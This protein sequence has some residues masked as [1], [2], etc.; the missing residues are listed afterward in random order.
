MK[1]SDPNYKP[2]RRQKF[3]EVW[4]GMWLLETVLSEP[5]TK[6][7]LMK[8]GLAYIAPIEDALKKQFISILKPGEEK[9]FHISFSHEVSGFS[10]I[11]YRKY[12]FDEELMFRVSLTWDDDWKYMKLPKMR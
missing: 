1:L 2:G 6:D 12:R 4:L 5:A 10:I 7:R 9:K 11:V 8:L 3:N